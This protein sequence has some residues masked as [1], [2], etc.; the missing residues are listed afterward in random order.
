MLGIVV[1]K[2]GSDSGALQKIFGLRADPRTSIIGRWRS[3]LPCG[4]SEASGIDGPGTIVNLP[5]P[6]REGQAAFRSD[7]ER[8][9]PEAESARIN[10][11]MPMLI[12]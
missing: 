3:V 5:E 1:P 2:M 9:C 6:E 7:Q 10:A 4:A 11:G 8:V 12:N